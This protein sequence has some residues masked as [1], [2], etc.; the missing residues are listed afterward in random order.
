MKKLVM[1]FGVIV[2]LMFTPLSVDA[3]VLEADFVYVEQPGDLAFMFYYEVEK[4]DLV[5]I[6]PS[7]LE[8]SEAVS[9]AS[10]LQ[11]S[12]GD[13]WISYQIIN[14]EAGQWT[15][16]YDKKGNEYIEYNL[17]EA[18]D[19]V[20]FQSFTINGIEGEYAN[21][22]FLATKGDIDEPVSYE[23]VIYAIAEDNE[24]I[25]QQLTSG[26]ANTGE[27]VTIDVQLK[28]SSYDKY[29][30]LIETV[31]VDGEVQSFDTF[32]TD[33]F[34]YINPNTPASLED[35]K[36][37]L[38]S[39]RGYVELNWKDYVPNRSVTE[40]KI[41]VVADGNADEPIINTSTEDTT[42]SFYYPTG[43][44]KLKIG[45]QYVWDG[46][47][48]DIKSKIIDFEA[49]EYLKVPDGDVVS[50]SLLSIEYNAT[51]DRE[52]SLRVNDVDGKYRITG[53]DSMNVTL[54]DGWNTV[55]AS[56]LGDDNITYVVNK[57]FNYTWIAPSIKLFEDLD[58]QNFKT[59]HL[60]VLGKTEN[61]E[62]LLVNDKEATM[63]EDG[64]FSVEVSLVGGENIITVEAISKTGVSAV[65]TFGVTKTVEKSVVAK[66]NDIIPTIAVVVLSILVLVI[67]F[68]LMREKKGKKRTFT[69]YMVC[70]AVASGIIDVLLIAAFVYLH[71]FNHS[72]KYVELVKT[73]VKDA[74]LYL[75]FEK[76]ALYGM[77]GAS[78]VFV[79]S[80]AAAI[81]IKVLKGKKK[82][83]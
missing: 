52:L 35:Y 67:F 78:V 34:S 14:A 50:D 31:T 70:L 49:G 6:S 63:N 55:E 36:V 58:G 39:S 32:T 61:A 76:Y 4:P 81:V 73:S 33:T 57:E 13:G 5:F 10:Q 66:A 3:E 29:K 47:A 38:D 80:V 75:D 43:T 17:L 46:V 15:L 53:Q 82:N 48:S 64:T 26:R 59:D 21:V 37:T 25:K 11:V 7:G 20:A 24:T 45:V 12:E 60:V 8:Y 22:S 65:K 83:A 74:A 40:Y 69:Y 72:M 27:T 19:N 16:R 77:I 1:F 62:K 71:S 54:E 44:S 2:A 42:A 28:I 23:Y 41:M 18:I 51:A 56:F 30:L 68:L 9:S 79:L